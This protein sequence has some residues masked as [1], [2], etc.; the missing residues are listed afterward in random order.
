[1]IDVVEKE[2]Q[3]RA[4]RGECPDCGT[5]LFQKMPLGRKGAPLTE[6]GKCRNGVCLICTPELMKEKDDEKPVVPHVVECF[7]SSW[8]DT[9]GRIPE[10]ADQAFGLFQQAEDDNVSVIT[11][12]KRLV[13]P[14]LDIESI[15]SMIMNRRAF[16]KT[17]SST[18]DI[19]EEQDPIDTE[20]GVEDEILMR[21]AELLEMDGASTSDG[22]DLRPEQGTSNDMFGDSL[23]GLSPPKV[24]KATVRRVSQKSTSPRSMSCSSS[25]SKRPFRPPA[26]FVPETVNET[27][28][29][30]D[31]QEIIL[32]TPPAPPKR[33]ISDIG[34]L[35][36]IHI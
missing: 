7:N 22:S 23:H 19:E 10:S 27:T 18:R 2:K 1:M 30:D 31:P 9:T 13:H 20:S 35:S 25:P 24:P 4:R 29:N 8:M 33:V 16:L 12:D 17:K 3:K 34:N 28:Q 11:L 26:V 5:R 21:M 6:E 36:L 15:R 32:E 14:D